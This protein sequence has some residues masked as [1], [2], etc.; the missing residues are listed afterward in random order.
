MALRLSRTCSGRDAPRM[1]VLV[2]GF[3][4]THASARC[5]SL[6]SSSAESESALL[7]GKTKVKNRTRT[8]LR[9]RGERLDLLELGLALL[10]A[11][12]VDR[13]REEVFMILHARA[14]GNLAV[15]VLARED[16]AVQRGEDRRAD[17]VLG[18]KR[19]G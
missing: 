19:A 10:L 1:T 13:L 14:F 3:F 9:E 4:A 18:V 15:V 16:A 2:Y 5:E 7:D 17:A 11:E 6:Q 8:R 12:A